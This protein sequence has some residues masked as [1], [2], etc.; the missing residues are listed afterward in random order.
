M[1]VHVHGVA[2]VKSD[3]WCGRLPAGIGGGVTDLPD[4]LQVQFVRLELFLHSLREE[5]FNTAIIMNMSKT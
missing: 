4:H 5:I 2:Q 1:Q 3:T